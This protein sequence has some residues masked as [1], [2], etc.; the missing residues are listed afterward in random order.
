MINVEDIKKYLNKHVSVTT[1][2]PYHIHSTDDLGNVIGTFER[3][4]E[5]KRLQAGL[6]AGQ[7]PPDQIENVKA[8]LAMMPSQPNV[9]PSVRGKLVGVSSSAIT[10]RSRDRGEGRSQREIETV[11]SMDL[12]S[13]VS[14]SEE[15]PAILIG[16]R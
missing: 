15:A 4:D 3:N 11:I 7:V 2:Q 12:V 16:S 10:L 13:F 1:R 9:E 14:V 8:V 6:R 5:A